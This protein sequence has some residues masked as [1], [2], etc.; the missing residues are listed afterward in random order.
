M[1][2]R[3]KCEYAHNMRVRGC[4]HYESAEDSLVCSHE[5]DYAEAMDEA[6]QEDDSKKIGELLEWGNIGIF[7]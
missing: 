7:K 6:R 1:E 5:C 4:I 2:R 3:V